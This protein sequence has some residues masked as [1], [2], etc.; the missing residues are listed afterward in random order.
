MS[1]STDVKDGVIL[2]FSGCSCLG[3]GSREGVE[4]RMEEVTVVEATVVGVKVV[5]VMVVL[6]R[7]LGS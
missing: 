4:V 7:A 5:V 3:L 6:E 2:M 1:L